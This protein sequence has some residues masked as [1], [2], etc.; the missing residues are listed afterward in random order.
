ME[1]A[2]PLTVPFGEGQ[3]KFEQE[4]PIWFQPILYKVCALGDLQFDWNSYGAK[5]IDP[6][7]AVTTLQIMLIVLSENDP[8]PAV[9]PTSSGGIM[10]EWHLAGIDLEVDVRSP[11][12]V[13][14]ACEIDGREEYLENVDIELIQDKLRI[15]RGRL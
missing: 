5:P 9:V 15:L 4:P 3:F 11:S 2:D 1:A 12:S 10:L 7:T 8:E 14:V 6:E 13:H